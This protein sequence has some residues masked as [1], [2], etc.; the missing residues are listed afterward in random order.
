[1]NGC[2][3]TRAYTSEEN[4]NL[5]PF[6]DFPGQTIMVQSGNGEACDRDVTSLGTR[7]E[8]NF[9]DDRMKGKDFYNC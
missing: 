9:D 7:K 4:I 1:M 8:L 6:T 5:K 3:D 2:F